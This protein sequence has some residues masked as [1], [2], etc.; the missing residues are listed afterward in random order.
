MKIFR[1]PHALASQLSLLK[2]RG[3]KVGLSHGVFDL[4]HPGHIQHF[5]AAKKQVDILVVSITADQYVNK[6]PGRPIFNEEIRLSTLAAL[7]SVD[8]VTI[9]RDKTAQGILSTLQPNIYF[10]G[11]DYRTAAQDPTG[12]IDIERKT[13]ENFGGELRFTD[14]FTS[15]S[16]RLI[17]FLLN[18]LNDEIQ[19]WVEN[20]KRQF[21]LE[22]IERCLEKVG[23]LNVSLVGEVII[24]QYTMVDALGKTG[25]DPILAFHLLDSEVY[26]GGIL[27]IANNCSSWVNSVEVHSMVG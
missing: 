6:G 9:S 18:P 17:N 10:K 11:S 19:N 24:D 8:F 22:E 21:Q 3:L 25:K 5:T 27:A 13:V 26:P 15:S 12:M 20:F 14:E 4:V 23:N 2:S 1:D 7:Q 16:S